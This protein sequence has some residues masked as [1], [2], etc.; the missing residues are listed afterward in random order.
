MRWSNRDREVVDYFRWV[1]DYFRE[2]VDYFFAPYR[3]ARSRTV[4]LFSPVTTLSEIGAAITHA[5]S[6]ST[7]N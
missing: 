2:V 5:A 3:R 4:A 6:Y 7:V 1:A